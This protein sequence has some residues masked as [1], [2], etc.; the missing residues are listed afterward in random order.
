M[1]NWKIQKNLA[2]TYLNY[3]DLTSFLWQKV[4]SFQVQTGKFNKQVIALFGILL[5]IIL[6][7]LWY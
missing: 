3:D 2:S 1:G 4:D 6:Y 7:S 5:F